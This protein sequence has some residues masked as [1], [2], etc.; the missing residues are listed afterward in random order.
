MRIKFFYIVFI[1]LLSIKSFAVEFKIIAVVG[2]E[3]ITNYDLEHRIKII[4]LTSV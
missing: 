1:T 3:V 4:S 2:D